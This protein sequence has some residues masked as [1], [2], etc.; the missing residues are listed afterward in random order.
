MPFAPAAAALLAPVSSRSS[1]L[2]KTWCSNGRDGLLFSEHAKS[3]KERPMERA[4]ALVLVPLL[5]LPAAAL[6]QDAPQQTYPPGYDCASVR[7]GSQRQA[8]EQS[9]LNPHAGDNLDGEQPITGPGQRTPGTVGPPTFPE[10][11]GSETRDSGPGTEG[12]A[13]G[14]GN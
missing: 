3:Q 8:C 13:G 12:G 5:V 9:R 11:P 10:E 4:C 14:V 7:A 1:G 6:A 2:V